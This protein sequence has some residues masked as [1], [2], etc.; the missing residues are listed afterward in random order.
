M[1]SGDGR[2][3]VRNCICSGEFILG[4]FWPMPANDHP[5]IP[6]RALDETIAAFIR[7]TVGATEDTVRGWV[8]LRERLVIR[9]AL[10][11]LLEV[12]QQSGSSGPFWRCLKHPDYRF[13]APIKPAASAASP[14]PRASPVSPPASSPASLPTA[15]LRADLDPHPARFP[16][17]L[18]SKECSCVPTCCP[19]CGGRLLVNV[20]IEPR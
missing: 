14:S 18:R 12:R 8:K 20:T 1:R 9:L 13:M 16:E 15:G 2:E 19:R 5:K 11:K 10:A 17:P 6:A 3:A 4:P 7:Q